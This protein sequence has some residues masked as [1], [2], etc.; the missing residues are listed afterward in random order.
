MNQGLNTIS[1]DKDN[2]ENTAKLLQEIAEKLYN[3]NIEILKEQGRLHE[4]LSRV[5]EVVFAVDVNHNL[6]LFNHIAEAI[7]GE[8]EKDV[9]GKHADDYVKILDYKTTEPIMIEDYAFKNKLYTIPKV[10]IFLNHENGQKEERFYTLK[11]NY[12]EVEGTK[13]EAVVSL[14]DITREVEIE[15]MKDDFISIASHE[16]KTPM[17]IVKNNLWM[18]RN[19]SKLQF[20]ENETR[21]MNEM[22]KG[23]ER[24]RNL[25]EELLNASRI[26]QNRLV[27]DLKE[28]DADP[29]VKSSMDSFAETIKLKNIKVTPPQP[30]GARVLVD[31]M[32]MQ[33]VMDN[34]ISNAIKYTNPEHPEMSVTTKIED[35]YFVFEVKDNGP[36]IAKS[37]YPK[38][39]TKFGRASEGLKLVSPGTSTGLGLYISKNF[40]EAMN[41]KIGFT[42]Q[43]GE[44]SM[45]WFKIPVAK[46]ASNNIVSAI[47]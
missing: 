23:L 19:T 42:S 10:K 29:L 1:P 3:K 34:F 20:N 2:T 15:H 30:T 33:Q 5:A 41:G 7:F 37:D 12:I 39:F 18:L 47:S 32:K 46:S 27:I 8:S 17:S 31:A 21:Y 9:I 14:A 36:G 28:Q 43:L 16:L 26:E 22:T 24:L 40:I 4:L 25:V 38:M 6:T 11:S 13:V 35:T 45:F 44:G